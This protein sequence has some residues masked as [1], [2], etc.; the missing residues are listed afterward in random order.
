MSGLSNRQA[1]TIRTSLGVDFHSADLMLQFGSVVALSADR[2]SS[3]PYVE[4]DSTGVGR[5]LWALSDRLQPLGRQLG[6]LD[7][8]NDFAFLLDHIMVSVPED[9]SGSSGYSR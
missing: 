8:Y 5:D 2:Y 4:A 9:T 3:L 7:S 1:T 6:G